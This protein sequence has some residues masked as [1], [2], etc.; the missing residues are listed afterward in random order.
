MAKAF[1][2]IMSNFGTETMFEDALKGAK[3]NPDAVAAAWWRWAPSA[4]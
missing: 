3:L 1:P 2:E 4:R